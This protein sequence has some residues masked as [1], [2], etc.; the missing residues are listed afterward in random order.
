MGRVGQ[1]GRHEEGWKLKARNVGG[2]GWTTGDSLARQPGKRT[3]HTTPGL[4]GPLSMKRD[5][6]GTVRPQRDDR[7]RQPGFVN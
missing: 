4:W 3:P 7:P 5:R 1:E 2:S 6:K